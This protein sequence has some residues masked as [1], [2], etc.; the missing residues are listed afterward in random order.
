MA[1]AV[2]MALVPRP[3]SLHRFPGASAKL[4][5][6]CIACR[7]PKVCSTRPLASERITTDWRSLTLRDR[8]FTTGWVNCCNRAWLASAS[9]S[10]PE[11]RRGK[12]SV[13]G[14]RPY[15]WLR[16]QESLSNGLVFTSGSRVNELPRTEHLVV[17]WLMLQY[18]SFM[19]S[20]VLRF[21]TH[22]QNYV[23]MRYRIT[24]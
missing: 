3:L 23:P 18:C 24:Y 13:A 16:N 1:S 22:K 21:A 19:V 5:A 14:S 10:S 17:G 11:P 9:A 4:C 8:V 7:L 20:H 15:C 2:P 6:F 12:S